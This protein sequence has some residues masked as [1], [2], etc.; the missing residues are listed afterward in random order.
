MIFFACPLVLGNEINHDMKQHSSCPEPAG[1][2]QQQQ[3]DKR[4]AGHTLEGAWPHWVLLVLPDQLLTVWHGA[5]FLGPWRSCLYGGLATRT[6]VV[7]T[8]YSAGILNPLLW[9]S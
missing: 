9:G 3:R 2:R 1:S 6:P 5:S 7:L 4:L 8:C